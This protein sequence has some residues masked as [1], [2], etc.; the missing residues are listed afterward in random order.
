VYEYHIQSRTFKGKSIALP[1]AIVKQFKPGH[2]N[3][4]IGPAKAVR[5]SEIE[6]STNTKVS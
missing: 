4:P 6:N 3:L 1:V 5:L 2:A